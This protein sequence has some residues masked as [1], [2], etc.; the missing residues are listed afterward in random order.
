MLA[1]CERGVIRLGPGTERASFFTYWP[2]ARARIASIAGCGHLFHLKRVF[3]PTP[4]LR[5]CQAVLRN[6]SRIAGV[7]APMRLVR[8]TGL[9]TVERAALVGGEGAGNRETSLDDVNART[10]LF[11]FGIFAD[12]VRD[13]LIGP[14]CVFLLCGWPQPVAPR[15]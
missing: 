4:E 8:S 3:Q 11:L 2:D 12:A 10:I 15:V 14:S 5:Y 9:T 6:S 7:H 13:P 1:A